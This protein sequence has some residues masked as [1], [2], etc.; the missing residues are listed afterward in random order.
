MSRLD[1]TLT[2]LGVPLDPRLAELAW[3]HRSWAYEN[4]GVPTNERLEFLG[5]SVLGVVVTEY[6]YV[7]F[8]DRPEG[9]LAKLRSA[10]VNAQSLAKVA[11]A[12]DLGEGLRLGRGELATGGRAKVSILADTMEAFIGA[13]HLTGG[14]GMSS[15]FVHHLFD[16]LVD[17][18]A[19]VGAGLD[20][21]TSLQEL[22]AALGLGVPT[23]D[24]TESGPDHDKRFEAHAVM[25]E[26]RFG[27]GK[28][29]NKKMAEQEA[30]ALAYA[31]LSIADAET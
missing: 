12:L 6:L 22:C 20:W 4:G 19:R 21:K 26:Y 17:E 8:P 3:T 25:G 18:A 5:D 11:L 31:A 10:V 7:T 16:P 1:E 27:P 2:E 15:R 24:M 30:A 23:Y 9:Q 14:I 29:L 13:V 28:G